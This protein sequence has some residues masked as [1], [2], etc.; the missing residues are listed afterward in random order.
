MGDCWS[1]AAT[2]RWRN[3]ADA[4]AAV[5]ASVVVV[6]LC[7]QRFV[8]SPNEQMAVGIDAVAPSAAATSL[9]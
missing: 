1:A 9:R 6:R 2:G 3:T 4:L 5:G 7:G 8:E